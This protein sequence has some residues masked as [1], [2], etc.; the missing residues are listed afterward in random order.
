MIRVPG[1]TSS[2]NRGARANARRPFGER[3][4]R[5]DRADRP[6]TARAAPSALWPTISPRARRRKESAFAPGR[7]CR[8]AR[9]G[10]AS[11]LPRWSSSRAHPLAV[12]PVHPFPFLSNLS[13]SLAVET[14]DPDTKDRGFARVKVPESLPRF[15]PFA[16]FDPTS[17]RPVATPRRTSPA[18]GPHARTSTICFLAWR[19]TAAFRSASPGT[20]TSTSSSRG[21]RPPVGGRPASS[22]A[23]VRRRRAA[24]GRRPVADRIRE[25]LLD[26][27]EIEDEDVYEYPRPARVWR[28]VSRSRCPA[29]IS[30]TRLVPHVP[31]DLDRRRPL[32][33]HPAARHLFTTLTTRSRR[34]STSS[35]GG[36]R[37]RR[38]RHQDD[39]LPR[40]I[41]RRGGAGARA[42]GGKR[43]AGGGLDRAQG[44]LRRGTNIHGPR[45]MER[46]G[47]HVFYG[48]R[49]SKTHAKIVAGGAPRRRRATALRPPGHRQLQRGARRESTRTSGFSPRI[50][51]WART[52]PSCSIRSRVR[53]EARA[54]GSSRLP[55]SPSPKRSS[56]RSPN[57]RLAR[58]PA[59][60]RY[61]FA[62]LNALGDVRII[63]ALYR[64]SAAGVNIDLWCAGSAAY[65]RAYPESP[66]TSGFIPSWDGFWST[67]GCSCSVRRR[68]GH[69]PLLG[70]LDAAQPRS[71]ASK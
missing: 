2:S 51:K 41:E 24:R 63:Q 21:G 25:L 14:L 13:L 56:A 58:S 7:R 19:S 57:R 61:I 62:K 15:V 6:L 30:T 34:C 50:P 37:S 47:V 31:S 39:A 12:D 17:L 44:P 33:R 40:R 55:P 60:A 48:L 49:E 54:T 35:A 42:G 59:A 27:L 9:A 45:S 32:R 4:A 69:L 29:P 52:P 67:S 43:Q 3:A 68:G 5:R 16:A 46:A 70:R 38:A 26:K 28:P 11:L 64:A 66:K 10:C 23:A 22:P 65:A 36:R 1:C 20:W 71:A 18:R 8:S 53:E